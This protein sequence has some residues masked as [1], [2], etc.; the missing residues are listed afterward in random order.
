MWTFTAAGKVSELQAELTA[1]DPS[2]LETSADRLIRSS[3]I[4]ILNPLPPNMGL[5]VQIQSS[6][7]IVVISL[8]HRKFG[9]YAI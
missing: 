7:D 8:M 4:G 9:N 5:V 3:V 6:N 2:T 1:I